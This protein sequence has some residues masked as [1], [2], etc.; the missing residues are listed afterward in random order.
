MVWLHIDCHIACNLAYK[1]F[2]YFFFFQAEDGMRYHCVTGVQ[3]CALPIFG[4]GAWT[5]RGDIPPEPNT[6]WD[7]SCARSALHLQTSGVTPD[8][9]AQPLR[10]PLWPEVFLKARRACGLSLGCLGR[11]CTR[12]QR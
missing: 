3:T 1:P 7:R 4:P 8:A 6:R 5:L 10:R 2:V 9:G 12:R 11:G